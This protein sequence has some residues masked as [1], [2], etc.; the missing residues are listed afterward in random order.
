MTNEE[1]YRYTINPIQA[2]KQTLENLIEWYDSEFENERT[3]Y[4]ELEADYQAMKSR[5][6]NLVNEL[7]GDSSDWVDLDIDKLGEYDTVD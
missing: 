1:V 7:I 3:A 6:E 4:T 2:A 5:H